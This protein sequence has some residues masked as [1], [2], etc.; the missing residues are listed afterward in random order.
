MNLKKQINTIY[1]FTKKEVDPKKSF[2]K[3]LNI[4]F[5]NQNC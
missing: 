1:T 2:R 5:L 3:I 4:F